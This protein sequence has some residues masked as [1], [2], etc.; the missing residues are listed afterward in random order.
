M[1]KIPPAVKPSPV[2]T[3]AVT[4]KAPLLF[5]T[6]SPRRKSEPPTVAEME[7]PSLAA[8]PPPITVIDAEPDVISAA[9]VEGP[10][11]SNTTIPAI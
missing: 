11:A 4:V 3:S 10:L 7:I 1:V 8:K 6:A 9:P 5:A 2:S